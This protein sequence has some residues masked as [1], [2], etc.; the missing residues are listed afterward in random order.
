MVRDMTGIT[1]YE[2]QNELFRHLRCSQ[3]KMIVP[4]ID[5]I[6]GF[7]ADLLCVTR[8]GYAEEYEIKLTLSDFRADLK[9]R[10]KHASLSG[11][12][13]EVPHPFAEYKAVEERTILIPIDST[14]DKYRALR[15]RCW[16]T[17]RPKRFWYVIC[18]FNVPEP[19]IPSYAGLMRYVPDRKIFESIKPAP[20]LKASPMNERDLHH[21]ANNMIW[22]Y[23]KIRIEKH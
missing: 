2:I 11:A 15:E 22:R 1:E 21:A 13:K 12:V 7:E 18:G 20:K 17:H 9:K 4:N 3:Y 8:A 5:C 23:W 16:P 19:E 6:T 10:A 14:A